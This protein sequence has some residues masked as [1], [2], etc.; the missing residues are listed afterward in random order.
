MYPAVDVDVEWMAARMSWP[1]LHPL[2]FFQAYTTLLLVVEVVVRHYHR[3]KSIL[4]SS[5]H[6]LISSGSL[7]TAF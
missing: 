7:K 3:V 1:S 2:H 4:N 6:H 5:T